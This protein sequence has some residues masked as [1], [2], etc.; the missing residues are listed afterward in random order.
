MIR[1]ELVIGLSYSARG[2]NCKKGEPFEVSDEV[3]AKLMATGRFTT[4]REVVDEAPPAAHPENGAVDPPA[5]VN[6]ESGQQTASPAESLSDD[7]I[8]RMTKPELIAL[9]EKKGIDI[10]ECNNNT[11]RAERIC[12]ALGLASNVQLGLE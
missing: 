4:V 2:V 8:G 9:A 12:R 11:E 5:N 7:K 1:L 3:A 10:S 6:G